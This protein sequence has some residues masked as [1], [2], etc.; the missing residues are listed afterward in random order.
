VLS[1]GSIRR[2]DGLF[3]WQTV[4]ENIGLGLRHLKNDEERQRQVRELLTLNPAGRI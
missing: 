3:P 2:Q 4:A 1:R